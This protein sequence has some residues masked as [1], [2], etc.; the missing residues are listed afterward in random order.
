M[1]EGG[2]SNTMETQAMLQVSGESDEQTLLP[3]E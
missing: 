3:G 2:T 1:G